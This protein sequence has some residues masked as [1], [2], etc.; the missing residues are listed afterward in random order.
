MSHVGDG[1]ALELMG[2]ESAA[3]RRIPRVALQQQNPLGLLGV[4][5]TDHQTLA[6][7]HRDVVGVARIEHG[8]DAQEA[9]LGQGLVLATDPQGRVEL[10]GLGVTSRI[11]LLCHNGRPLAIIEVDDAVD[12]PQ[13]H[14]VSGGESAELEETG[15]VVVGDQR[16]RIG[17][18]VEHTDHPRVVEIVPGR[19][20]FEMQSN[21]V[22]GAATWRWT[23]PLVD[24]QPST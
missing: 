4:I 20:H 8:H 23:A 16:R 1:K 21:N 10:L 9:V 15:H 19:R 22:S 12:H 11:D 24:F 3:T 5:V 18:G 14:A 7:F 6:V 2:Q 13:M 17:G